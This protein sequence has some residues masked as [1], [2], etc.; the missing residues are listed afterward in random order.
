VRYDPYMGRWVV[1][2]QT[3]KQYWMTQNAEKVRQK[4]AEEFDTPP[5]SRQRIYRIRD[6]PDEAG[7][8]RNASRSGPQIN[9]IT[10]ENEMLV[11]QAFTNS[12]PKKSKQRP[13]IALGISRR[14]LRRLMQRLG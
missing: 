4:R 3:V 7:S 2:R 11:S 9:V 8:I 10:Q 12:S 6:K 13:S 1:R 14:S 5:P